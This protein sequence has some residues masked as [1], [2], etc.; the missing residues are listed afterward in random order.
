MVKL[1]TLSKRAGEALLKELKAAWPSSIELGD[2]KGITIAKVDDQT[3]LFFSDHF[4]AIR[5]REA[6]L[7]FLTEEKL[8]D[9]FPKVIVDQGAVPF[10]CNGADV[11]R[12]GIRK[13]EG[14]FK[15]GDVVV[16]KDERH[17]KSIAVGLALLDSSEA[18]RMKKGAVIENLHY[19]GDKLWKL[20]KEMGL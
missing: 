20:H 5:A 9:A 16:V 3:E 4:K 1:H 17:R 18:S 19:V 15:K 13:F 11:M 14:E 12:P 7:P 2:P 8:L 10:I 6:L